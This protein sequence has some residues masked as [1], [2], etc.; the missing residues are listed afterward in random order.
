MMDFLERNRF[1]AVLFTFLTAVGI[2]YISSLRF[3]SLDLF[4][5]N[6][7]LLTYL[8]HFT[9]FFLLNFFLLIS[10]NGKN[11]FNHKYFIIA[12]IIS[13]IYAVLDET[14]QMFVPGRTTDFK[15]LLVDFAGIFSSGILYFQLKSKSP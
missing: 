1:L 15:D 3:G 5:K 14:H 10:I 6:Q 2:F 7:I 13:S 9:I 12:I 11:K 4:G 8:Y